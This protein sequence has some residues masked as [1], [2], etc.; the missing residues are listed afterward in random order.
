MS[1]WC[2]DIIVIKIK[3]KHCSLCVDAE[4][5]Q[6]CLSVAFPS[7][8]PC[9]LTSFPLL[10]HLIRDPVLQCGNEACVRRAAPLGIQA[11]HT[12]EKQRGACISILYCFLEPSC[13]GV[14]CALAALHLSWLYSLMC[15]HKKQQVRFCCVCVCVCFHIYICHLNCLYTPAQKEILFLDHLLI[16]SIQNFFFLFFLNS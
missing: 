14:L 8:S 9:C 2:S 6:S 7:V 15:C 13:L 3:K 12:S 16:S 11:P 4:K 1:S 10:L 5:D